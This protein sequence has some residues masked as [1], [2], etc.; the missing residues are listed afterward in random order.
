MAVVQIGNYYAE[1]QPSGNADV[2]GVGKIVLRGATHLSEI[3]WLTNL[4]PDDFHVL[5]KLLQTEKPLFWD[6]E[7][8]CLRTAHPQTHDAEP[9]GEQEGH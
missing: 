2:C 8:G 7:A 1:W 9:V 5:L 3:Y 6:D 4:G